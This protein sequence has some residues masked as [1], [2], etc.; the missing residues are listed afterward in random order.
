MMFIWTI[1]DLNRQELAFNR[2]V[3]T[4]RVV[5]GIDYGDQNKDKTCTA[6]VRVIDGVFTVEGINVSEIDEL[7]KRV[8]SSGREGV[9]TAHIRDDYEPAGDMM[10]RDM[11]NSG[12][13]VQ[14]KAPMHSSNQK[15]RIFKKGM[16]PY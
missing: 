10:I 15:W 2:L 1:S 12:E 6:K 3:K 16:E 7:K 5:V 14:R 4:G 13:Y 8:D 9:L 11:T